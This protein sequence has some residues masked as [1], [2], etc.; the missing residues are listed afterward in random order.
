MILSGGK[1]VRMGQEIDRSLVSQSVLEKFEV[2]PGAASRRRV[3]IGTAQFV[4]G[5]SY[6]VAPDATVMRTEEADRLKRAA[7]AMERIRRPQSPPGADEGA[8]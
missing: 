4:N 5:V 1:W 8:H 6:P 2:R 7:A 3:P